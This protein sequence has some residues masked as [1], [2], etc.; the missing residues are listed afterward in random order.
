LIAIAPP[1]FYYLNFETTN[2][3]KDAGFL[4]RKYITANR[5]FGFYFDF[6]QG[7]ILSIPFI[8]IAYIAIWFITIIHT[9]I[10]KLKFDLSLMLPL[11]LVSISI[12]VCSM[13]NWNHGMAIINRY[14]SWLSVFVIVHLFYLT[15]NLD[16]LKGTVLFNYFFLTQCFTTLYHEQF[17]KFGWS[18]L[19]H[20]PLAKW[21]L[22]YHPEWYDPDPFIFAGRTV[23]NMP[24]IKENSPFVF[25]HGNE[26]K[27]MLINKDKTDDLLL[28]GMTK[29]NV[30]KIKHDTKFNFD[31]G[32]VDPIYF[33]S[34]FDGL[35]VKKVI[36]DRKIQAAA[37]RILGSIDWTAQIKQKA[38]DWGK[39]FDEALWIDAEYIVI[40][41]EKAEE[42]R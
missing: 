16:T 40:L 38:K 13:G 21:F 17:N 41:D 12:I 20:T 18:S 34:G 28:F 19:A 7:M 33:K 24:L 6:N 14:A 23:L 27:K 3:I 42:K 9:I 35:K 31:W 10:R 36:R 15:S 32:Y 39:T 4:D 5:V 2:L 8:L 25:F 11:V 30:E 29:E 1:I 22:T 37:G 26:I